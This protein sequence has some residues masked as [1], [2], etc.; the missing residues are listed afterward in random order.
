M[1]R[2][3]ATAAQILPDCPLVVGFGGWGVLGADLPTGGENPALG[4]EWGEFPADDDA[5]FWIVVTRQP[6]NGTFEMQPDTSWEYDGTTDYFEAQLYLDNVAEGTAQR[7]DLV[8]GGVS[9]AVEGTNGDDSVV[10]TGTATASGTIAVSEAGDTVFVVGS[11]AGGIAVLE[12]GDAVFVQGEA[13]A[14]GSISVTGAGD[15]VAIVG[16]VPAVATI[17]LVCAGDTVSIAG[18]AITPVEGSVSISEASDAAA[19]VAL[20][21]VFGSVSIT[22]AGDVSVVVA[23]GVSLS[24]KRCL[25]V[26][27]ENRRLMV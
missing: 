25:P 9:A 11:V 7:V 21:P 13:L 17:S 2:L 26:A 15:S 8:V 22:E 20:V 24:I 27:P 18:S 12:T 23:A 6:V 10:V 3:R 5:E 16:S 4:R 1:S 14:A 19:V